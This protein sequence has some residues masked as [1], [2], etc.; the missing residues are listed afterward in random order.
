M[1]Q[2][3]ATL[4][5]LVTFALVA[6][7]GAVTAPAQAAEGFSHDDWTT[8]LQKFVD[9]QGLVD[10][11]ALSRDRATF[12]RYLA[13]VEKYSPES[14]PALFRS[15]DE[16][17]AYYLNAYNAQVFAG[18]LS[19]GPETDS[20][21]SGLISGYTFFQR[22]KV[23]IGGKSM[24][25][26]ALEDDYV[27]EKFGDPRIHAA[28]NCASIGCPRLPRQAFLPESL[29]EQ[30]DAA[31]R[32]FVNTPRHVTVDRAAKKATISKIFDWFEGDFLSYL[33]RQGVS[34]PGILDYLNRYRAEGA[35]IP[36]DFS[37]DYFPYDKGINQQ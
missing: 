12:D 24:S 35:E 18:V 17:L 15:R 10:Y 6:L 11:Q 19:R 5:A 20:V 30:L 21:W 28:L 13:Q 32:E 29:N 26:K 34:S 14:S 33:K 3:N 23:T 2:F 8:V 36:T 1:P 22:M 16:Q 27:R 25:L 31:M 9:D 7:L 4:T 37:V